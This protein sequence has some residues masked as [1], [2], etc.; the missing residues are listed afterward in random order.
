MGGSVINADPVMHGRL[1]DIFHDGTGLYTGIPSP[2]K[3]VRYHS[4]IVSLVDLP[5]ELMITSW[6]IGSAKVIMGLQHKSKPI[7]SV[8]FHPESI[9]TEFGQKIILNFC[10][11]A[12][13][14]CT[15]VDFF[16][17]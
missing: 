6:S 13:S 9:C 17:V 5:S 8:Q 10:D 3:A 7:H 1:S 2:F 16:F 15:E 11:M 4:L 12:E 14:Y